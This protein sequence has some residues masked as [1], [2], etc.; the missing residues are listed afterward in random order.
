M[1]KIIILLVVCNNLIVTAQ[2]TKVNYA[3]KLYNQL[4]YFEAGNVF[5]EVSIKMIKKNKIDKDVLNKTIES[6]Y[7][8]K[9]YERCLYYCEVASNTNNLNE[10][11]SFIYFDCILKLKESKKGFNYNEFLQNKKFD[12]VFPE[13]DT[14]IS[15]Y[16]LNKLSSPINSGSGN[17][18]IIKIDD[19]LYFSSNRSEFGSYNK[20]RFDNL[21][22][23]NIHHYNLQTKKL[24]LSKKFSSKFNDGPIAFSN[25]SLIYLT[26]NTN[27]DKL[28]EKKNFGLYIYFPFSNNSVEFIH[29]SKD[30]NVGH[31]AFDTDGKLY[32]TSNMPGGYG[33]Y[34]IY[35]C[36]Q[37]NGIW[38]KPI[39]AGPSVNTKY[40]E[41]YPFMDENNNLYF[42]SNMPGGHGGLDI[43]VY[44]NNQVNNIGYPFNSAFDDFSY[45][46]SGNNGYISSDRENGVDNIYSFVKKTFN[47]SLYI[48]SIETLHKTELK[49]VKY[50]LVNLTDN[51]TV[52]SEGSNNINLK[53]E[54][55][56]YLYAERENS[57]LKNP[58]FFN[59][60]E[61]NEN[62]T[63]TKELLFNNY[64]YDLKV[65]TVV[66]GTNEPLPGVELTF[67][68]RVT[69]LKLDVTTDSIG[70]GYVNL[71]NNT[72]FDYY[73]SKK[74]YL[75]IENNVLTDDV[76][77]VELDL[78]FQKIE[79]NTTF[80]INNILYD[81]G[82]WNLKD[83][84]ML[85]LDKLAIFLQKNENIKIELSSH[86]DSRSSTKFNDELSQKRAQSCV[87]YLIAKG[88]NQNRIIAK[89]YGERKLLN[90]CS[91]KNQCSEEDHSLN[92]RTEI[93]ILDVQ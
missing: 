14:T 88:I 28:K 54:K 44:K 69:K 60:F 68:D 89:G 35:Y 74:G 86:T 43:Y 37:N 65:I 77:L 41:S 52:S 56:Y 9:K 27:K 82:K 72:Y 32:F 87:N 75:N 13:L 49:N 1:R 19:D 50:F 76:F 16:Q 51:D 92:R 6:L 2:V 59:T 48:S 80:K 66:K 12:F 31:A 42:S 38:S 55:D 26:R 61:V 64:Q 34:D 57:E 30:Y 63:I 58:Q 29:N 17:Y 90:N 78:N 5:E 7:Y 22:F 40:N 10:F 81:L 8:T 79:K 21:N 67:I 4:A 39:N 85:E 36:T 71:A 45:F 18:S 47:V 25:D 24:S 93:K 33:G 3:T 62:D 11:S 83:S 46:A 23:S 15:K 20:S 70:I 53:S 73:A 84:S 91:D